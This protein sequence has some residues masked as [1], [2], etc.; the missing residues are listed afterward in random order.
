MIND[1]TGKLLIAPPKVTNEFWS[2]SVILVTADAAYGSMGLI[3]N[4]RSGVSLKD[5]GKQMG[6]PLTCPGFVY[7]GGPLHTSRIGLI[8]TSE[9]ESA[10][11]LPI[12]PDISLSSDNTM[13]SRIAHGDTPSQWRL[14]VGMCEWGAFQLQDEVLGTPPRNHDFSWCIVS[15]TRSLVFGFYN[16]NQWTKA[17][18][19]AALEFSRTVILSTVP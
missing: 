1:L 8:H 18:D 17:I 10:N 2:K 4:K 15:S 11:T 9:W 14:M 16:D 3:L 12:T 19:S 13:L 7:M 5:F 6:C